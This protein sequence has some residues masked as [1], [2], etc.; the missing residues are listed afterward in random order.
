M[1]DPLTRNAYLLVI[2]SVIGSVTM[3]LLPWVAYTVDGETSP[4]FDYDPDYTNYSNDATIIA[5]ASGFSPKEIDDMADNLEQ[6]G[7]L[8]LLSVLLSVIGLFGI[9]LYRLGF[10]MEFAWAGAAVPLIAVLILIIT[11]LFFVNIGE[12]DEASDEGDWGD[13]DDDSY[14]FGGNVIPIFAAILMIPAGIGH[15]KALNRI[16]RESMM[17][18]QEQGPVGGPYQ[19]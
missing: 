11:G 5:S 10:G 19:R 13:D 16:K 17:R 14:Y 18:Y 15:I 9:I 6:I 8:F 2:L 1:R 7:T 3:P 4:Y 12:L